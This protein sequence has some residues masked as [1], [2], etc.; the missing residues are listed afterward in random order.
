MFLVG[1]R[2]H[3]VTCQARADWTHTLHH[4]TLP[5]SSCASCGVCEPVSGHGIGGGSSASAQDIFQNTSARVSYFLQTFGPF[6][7]RP[8]P[9]SF[10]H[11]QLGAA[12]D[13]LEVQQALRLR[14]PSHQTQLHEKTKAHAPKSV[15]AVLLL[16]RPFSSPS[17]THNSASP[18]PMLPHHSPLP[19]L[20]I[21]PHRQDLPMEQ[22]CTASSWSSSLHSSPRVRAHSSTHPPQPNPQEFTLLP[23][24]SNHEHC[25]L[26]HPQEPCPARAKAVRKEER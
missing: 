22:K 12:L 11:P 17:T 1:S 18:N 26:R 13:S 24:S 20:P 7:R 6:G 21:P 10:P 14:M 23:S 19:C 25:R 8:L 5:C 2:H 4:H 15:A 9:S 3:R 16:T